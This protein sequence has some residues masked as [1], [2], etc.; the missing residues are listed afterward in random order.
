[1]AEK[2]TSNPYSGAADAISSIAAG[3][4]QYQNAR[5]DRKLADKQAKMAGAM[6][7]RKEKVLALQAQAAKA[8]LQTTMA[9][10][11][12]MAGLAIAGII[13]AVFIL[14]RK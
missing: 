3:F 10:W 8:D 14:K 7:A 12:P 2:D 9:T 4:M 5:E 11:L 13:G 6:A 1:M